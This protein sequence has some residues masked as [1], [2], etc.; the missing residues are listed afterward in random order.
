MQSH[1][2]IGWIVTLLWLTA[3]P[4]WAVEYRLQVA[5]IDDETFA[6]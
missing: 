3:M 6:S 5:N 1:T 4:A 2:L